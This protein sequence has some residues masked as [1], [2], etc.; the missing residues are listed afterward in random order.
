ML[1]CPIKTSAQWIEVL[2]R[3]N[4]NEKK[5]YKI[6]VDEGYIDNE[7][8]NELDEDSIDI[9]VEE[10]KDDISTMVD[11][12]RV[13]LRKQLNILE[14]QKIPNQS[15]KEKKQKNLIDEFEVLDGIDSITM[16]I[17]DTYIK[18]QSVEKR[19]KAILNKPDDGTPEF[20]KNLIKELTDINSFVNGYSILD[21]ISKDDIYNYFSTE[22]DEILEGEKKSI[23]QMLTDAISTRKAVKE[24]YVQAGI[25]LMASFLLNYKSLDIDKQV[26]V[27]VEA[28]KKRLI[29]AKKSTKPNQKEIDALTNRILKF[30]SF[31]LTQESM[32]D[33]LKFASEDES[34]LDFWFSPLI[35]SKDASLGLFARFVK[36]EL[37][38]ASL[39]DDEILEITGK[40]F[41]KY[42]AATSAS[43][44]NPAKFNEGIY[45]MLE[46]H[47]KNK[48]GESTVTKRMAFV[49]KYRMSDYHAAEKA[50]WRGPILGENPTRAELLAKADHDANKR[51]IMSEW[52]SKNAQK[53]SDEEIDKILAEKQK[54]KNAGVLTDEEYNDWY[55]SVLVIKKDGTKIYMKEFSEPSNDYINSKWTDMYNLDG[56][57]KNAKGEYHKHLLDLYLK[58]QEKVPDAQK[59]GYILPSI[60]KQDKERRG[61]IK[62]LLKDKWKDATTI[63]ADDTRF[64]VAD[65]SEGDKK[66]LPVYYTQDMDADEVSLDLVRSVLLYSQMANR[67]EAI[68]NVEPEINLFKTI[69]GDREVAE[70]NSKGVAKLDAFANKLGI[71]SFIKKQGESY[72]AKHVDAFVDMIIFNETQ[73]A[74][75]IFGFSAAKITNGLMGY[76]AVVSIAGD[77]LKGI[78]NNLQGNIQ[79]I[80]EAN[81]AEFF[82]RKDL[83]VGK[84]YYAKNLVSV[85][86][87]FGKTTPQSLVGKMIRLY[88]PMQGNFKDQYGRN[89]S[90]SMFAKLMR[91]D[92]LFFNQHFGEHEIQVSGML[93]LMN[94]TKVIDKVSGEEISLLDAYTK[95][96]IKDI[97]QHTDFTNIK[98]LDLQNRIHA[99][100]K[101]LHGVYNEFDKSTA[102]R[103]SG[104][105]LLLM[106]KKHLIPGYKR[107][108]GKLQSDQELGSAVEGYYRTFYNTMLKDLAKMRLN[109]IKNWATYTPFEKAQIKR[110]MAETVIILGITAM[111][112]VMTKLFGGDDDDENTYA[113][114][115]MLYELTRMQ[116]ETASYISPQDAYRTVKSPTAMVSTIERITKFVDQFI[117]TWDP[118]KLNYQR[119]EGVWNKGDNKSWAYFLKLIGFSGY[120]FH[121][122]AAVKS[123]KA[124]LTK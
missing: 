59:R 42:N 48:Q 88:D 97:E 112:L 77:L 68:N 7:T 18:S 99:I 4:G 49:Q 46:F 1:G 44:D 64:G 83:R 39:K 121:P 32:E 109:V 51:A 124:T 72:S 115:F 36:T 71:K 101:K 27:E 117:L 12:I 47:G 118:E 113:Y 13:Y 16:F 65:L 92:T 100:S 114:N 90:P 45:E 87:D 9:P 105:R 55:K 14:K 38:G 31:T 43:R 110:T 79:M 63:R 76:S 82:S 116:S 89:V 85:L 93:A 29:A 11:K 73:K 108:W 15:Y 78:A 52:Y 50:A 40:E 28:L 21:E 62:G 80:I 20:K 95:Y 10:R 23:K 91:T 35:S 33:L 103:Y 53:K 19:I 98:R 81:S 6:W 8:I 106:Y 34:M 2:E 3:A 75:E 58:A 17:K 57:P 67:Y 5:A 26:E 102:Q 111:I 94:A 70:T 123:F 37:D 54:L 56:T 24:K 120:N 22:S 60:H 74:Q 61:D 104:G 66:F 41:D 69:I 25:P 96:G 30:E 119:N 86:S 84:T 107:R 122:E